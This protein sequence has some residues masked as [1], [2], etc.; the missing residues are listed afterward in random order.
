MRGRLITVE[1]I[2]GAGKTTLLQGLAQEL[3]QQGVAVELL[4]EPGSDPLGER[5]REVVSEVGI[6]IDPRAETLLYAAA[7]AQLT[8]RRLLPLLK[9]GK[10]V[11]LDRF[12]DSSLAYQ[13]GGRELGI[14]PVRRINDFAT[15]GLKPDRTVLIEL[16]P[17]LALARITA[18]RRDRL[19]RGGERFFERVAAAYRAL[20]A[21]EPERIV[22]LDGTKTPAELL[23]EA[24]GVVTA[25]LP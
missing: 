21:E 12:T 4:R 1:G 10:V 14:E 19:E 23:A 9:E 15:G 17:A 2:D 13:G 5:L 24:L 18:S 20:A 8:S 16:P 7:R 3:R 6:Q 22:V 11:L 25:I